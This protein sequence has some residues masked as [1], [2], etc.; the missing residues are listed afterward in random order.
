MEILTRK[1]RDYSEQKYCV[2][3]ERILFIIVNM[4]IIVYN[5]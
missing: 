3:L 4:I 1:C 2:D 5:L